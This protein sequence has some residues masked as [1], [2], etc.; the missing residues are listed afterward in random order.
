MTIKLAQLSKDLRI[1]FREAKD[2][3]GLPCPVCA[4]EL[5]EKNGFHLLLPAER[6]K[7]DGYTDL[8]PRTAADTAYLRNIKYFLRNSDKRKRGVAP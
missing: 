3:H 4:R 6:C 5:A 2:K 1:A 8:R 7:R